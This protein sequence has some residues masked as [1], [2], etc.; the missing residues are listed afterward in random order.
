VNT[1]NVPANGLTKETSDFLSTL[2]G[3]PQRPP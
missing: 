3:K 1:S 2:A